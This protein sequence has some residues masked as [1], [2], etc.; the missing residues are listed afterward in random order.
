[1][2]HKLLLADDS[3]TIQ[4]VIE[5]TFADEDIEV[6]A[7]GDG[8]QAIDRIGADP[9]DVV[10]A[11]VGMPER[12]GYQVASF[13]K[14]TPRLAHIPVLLLTGAFEPVDE[15]RARAAGCDGVLVKPFEP[16]MVINRVKDLLAG[17]R[18][19]AMWATPPAQPA[20]AAPSPPSPAAPAPETKPAADAAPGS[21]SLDD[22]FDRLDAAFSG[23]GAEPAAAAEPTAEARPAGQ[24]A[25]AEPLPASAFDTLEPEPPAGTA[26]QTSDDGLGGWDPGLSADEPTPTRAAA[27][28]PPPP[29]PEVSAPPPEGGWLDE[30]RQ[31][32]PGL[33][34]AEQRAP[35]LTPPPPAAPQASESVPATMPSLSDAFGALLAAE[36]EQPQPAAPAGAPVT[37]ETIEL[38][39]QK[40]VERLTTAAVRETV[41]DV[42]ERLVREEIARIK[43]GG[44]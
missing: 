23:L 9:P 24:A 34:P 25:P 35:A 28:L 42:A 11:D 12:D 3:V 31:A 15:A 8:Q 37:D 38:V 5:L 33:R 39:V 22:Y 17:R 20:E 13:V 6:V 32:V 30:V 14:Q 29:A 7:V 44:H 18:S 1:M 21:D 27:P 26:A 41:T 40:V 36:Q 43:S 2:A 4:R 19:D 10:L 16:Q